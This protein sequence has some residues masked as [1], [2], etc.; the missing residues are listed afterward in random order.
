MQKYTNAQKKQFT[1]IQSDLI[2][3]GCELVDLN[4]IAKVVKIREK[5]FLTNVAKYFLRKNG[6]VYEVYDNDDEQISCS[7]I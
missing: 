1:P 4:V 3:G 2:E 7:I 6:E 5:F